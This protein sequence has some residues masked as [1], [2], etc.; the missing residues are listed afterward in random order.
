VKRRALTLQLLSAGR[1]TALSTEGGRIRFWGLFLA[2]G[3]MMLGL[4][5]L[6]LADATYE[7][8][9]VRGA[10]RTPQILQQGSADR[11]VA[12][13]AWGNDDV[14]GR[15]HSVT[16]IE[17]LVQNAPLPPGLSKWPEPGEAVLSPA[18]IRAG[19]QEGIESRYG[20]LAGTIGKEGLQAP[21][22]RF[23]Y[24]RPRANLL[25][26]HDMYPLK[27]FG[28]PAG[29]AAGVGE[30]MSIPDLSVL[31]AGVAGFVLLPT[32]A[33]VLVSACAGSTA[34]ERRLAL[35]EA[36]GASRGARGIFTLGE[37]AVP[38]IL[39]AAAAACVLLP[40][41]MLDIPFPL[42]DF[43]LSAEDV[44]RSVAWLVVAGVT[45]VLAV[46][47]AAVLLH[48]KR[49]KSAQAVRPTAGSQRLRA[50]SPWMFPFALLFAVRGPE[51]AGDDLRLPVY[52]V[53]V[54]AVLVTLPAVVG[55]L[56]AWLGIRFAIVGGRL[57]MPGLLIAGRRISAKPR[58]TARFVTALIV[59]IGL[60]AQVQLWTGLLGENATLAKQTQD[61]IGSTLLTVSPYADA[62]RV[63]D[64][65][66][67]MPAETELLLVRQAPPTGVSPGRITLSGTCA[68]LRALDLPCETSRFSAARSGLDPRVGELARWS[69]AGGDSIVTVARGPVHGAKVRG[70]ESLSLVAV[71]K[72][73]K[74]LSLPL[75]REVART[76]LAARASVDPL[77]QGWLLGSNDL[78]AAA[79]WVRLLGLIGACLTVLAIGLGALAEFLR[80][81]RDMAPLSVL[82]GSTRVNG[83]VVAWSLLFPA[84]LAAALGSIV[85]M[86]LTTPISV[87]GGAP[88][89]GA[90]YVL[91]G[92]GAGVCA[93]TLCAWGWRS[94]NRAALRWR[95]TLD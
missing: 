41:F 92:V 71:A 1:T 11:A 77:G 82:T 29:S 9:D 4:S 18:L 5:G 42:V 25:D 10:S 6:A 59:M 64:F 50:W 55:A 70:E 24:V 32:G 78:A 36:L 48:S 76:H 27:G 22:E 53:G 30:S 90:T 26:K 74:A 31:A 17:P 57:G 51:L 84:L 3:L 38:T 45:A 95:P 93:A 49:R 75:L 69:L 21:E 60:V 20:K 62:D 94:T 19:A 15:Q 63:Q 67:A 85:S 81:G 56:C 46:L 43:T 39:G 2:A 13:W 7:G 58:G 73:G 88:V 65:A 16:Y 87:D 86:W 80:F 33:L 44:R 35:F 47:T 40:A 54:A 37:A 91:L 72:S 52:A 66:A 8:R 14:A 79:A 61:R 23:A 34:R 28:V 12:L 68:A 89:P 83:S